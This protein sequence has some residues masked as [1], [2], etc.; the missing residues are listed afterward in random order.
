[1]FILGL[2]RET[3]ASK[4]FQSKCVGTLD[5]SELIVDVLTSLRVS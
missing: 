1:M 4:R 3:E 2:E 5:D